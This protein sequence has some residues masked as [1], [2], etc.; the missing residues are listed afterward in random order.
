M[1][2]GYSYEITEPASRNFDRQFRPELTPQDVLRLG[3]FG[4]K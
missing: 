1:Q 4:G 2:H 3:V